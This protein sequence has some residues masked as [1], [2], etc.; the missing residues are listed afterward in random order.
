MLNI[1]N[2]FLFLMT[3]W[4]LFMLGSSKVSLVYFL[5]GTI[6]SFLISFA[7]FK[8]NIFNKKSELLYLSLGFYKHFIKIYLG[9]VLRSLSLL[10]KLAFK[11]CEPNLYQLK[12]NEKYLTNKE[13]LIAS[14]NMNAGMFYVGSKKDDMLIHAVSKDS[15]ERIDIHKLCLNLRNI[16]DDSLV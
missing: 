7:S 1:F 14:I 11:S 9:E 3:L 12:L 5:L 13:L 10:V 16:N 8:A 4:G 2:F 15:F 6:S